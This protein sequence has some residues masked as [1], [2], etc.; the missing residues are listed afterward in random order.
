M[1]SVTSWRNAGA[2]AKQHGAVAVLQAGRTG[3]QHQRLSVHV[4]QRVALVA[5]HLT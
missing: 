2:V 1:L 5:S 4:H 3:L